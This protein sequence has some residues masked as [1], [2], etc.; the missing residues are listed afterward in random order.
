MRNDHWQRIFMLRANVDEMNIQPTDLG[1]EVRYRGQSC[2]ASAPIMLGFPV[3]R[4]LSHRSELNALRRVHYCL[5]VGPAR[6]TDA[7]LQIVERVFRGFEVESTNSGLVG[8]SALL[9]KRRFDSRVGQRGNW[10]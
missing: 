8:H 7:L 2:L 4:E 3:A 9:W 6:R 10:Q 1:D 5:L